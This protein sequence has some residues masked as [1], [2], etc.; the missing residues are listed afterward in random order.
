MT[1]RYWILLLYVTSALYANLRGRVRFGL[2]RSLTDFTVLLAPLN[3]VLYL[4]SRVRPRPYLA[5]QA[6]PDLALLTQHWREIRDEALRLNESAT[7]VPRPTTT[8]S[9]STRSFAPAGSAST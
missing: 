4:A 2:L 5:P 7:S 6:F 9:A 3:A 1:L 8:T